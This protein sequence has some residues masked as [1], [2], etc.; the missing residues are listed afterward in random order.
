M[1]SVKTQESVTLPDAFK[2]IMRWEK[3]VLVDPRTI[4]SNPLNW[5][6][7]PPSQTESLM[8]A[9]KRAGF[10]LPLLF[11]LTTSRLIDGH[12]RKAKAISSGLPAVPVALGRWTEE[13]EHFLL[14]TIDPIGGMYQTDTEKLSSLNALVAQGRDFLAKASKDTKTS[15]AKLQSRLEALPGAI[16]KGK[17]TS[18]PLPIA[19][20]SSRKQDQEDQDGEDDG[21]GVPEDFHLTQDTVTSPKVEVLAEDVVFPSSNPW[22]IPDYDL[23]WLATSEMAPTKT[24]D[25]SSDSVT[26]RS[27]YCH[28]ARPFHIRD[29]LDIHGGV[30]GFFCEDWRFEGAYDNVAEFAAWVRDEQ[31]TCVLQP[32]FSVYSAW[33]FPLR[34]WNLYRSRW[35]ARYWQSLNIFVMPILQSVFNPSHID[36]VDYLE[37]LPE[38]HP[39]RRYPDLD[40]DDPVFANYDIGLITMPNP[41]PIFACQCRTIKQQGGDFKGFGKWLAHRIEY[42][43][44]EVVVIY[45]AAEHQSKFLGYLPKQSGKLR[46]VMLPSYMAQRRGWMKKAKG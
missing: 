4:D 1:S 24:Y 16:D 34:L 8:A 14:Q 10:V 32:D 42:L 9:I 13:E 33:P 44:P 37:P 40:D 18:V 46:Y 39:D 30:Y 26:D 20:L 31:W 25:R 23:A 5:K 35:V 3:L 22:N 45:G 41:C 6:Q 36:L 27:Y 28:S 21:E 29:D 15:L 11:N 19:S 7:H 17:I 2:E 12:G 43:N 38:D